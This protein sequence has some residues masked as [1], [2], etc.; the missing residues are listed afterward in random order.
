MRFP[1][2]LAPAGFAAVAAL[3]ALTACGGSSYGGSSG[4]GGDGQNEQAPPYLI[5]IQDMAFSPVRLEVP[6]GATV[7][8][9]NR[10][11]MAHSVTSEA[12]AEDF[13]PGDVAGIAFDTGVFTG[14]RTFT[15][16]ASA[17]TGTEIPYYCSS[18]LRTMATPTGTIVVTS[19]PSNAGADT[20]SGTG[21]GGGGMGG[22]SGY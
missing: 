6:P 4:S 2:F 22:G 7:T 1:A 19:T 21:S 12:A 10:D 9:R 17:T 15:I 8:V 3:A 5:V 20:G 18:H 11:A 16:P 13:R 14:E